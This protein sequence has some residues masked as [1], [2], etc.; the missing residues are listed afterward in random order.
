MFTRHVTAV[1]LTLVVAVPV[2][3]GCSPNKSSSEAIPAGLTTVEFT[4]TEELS[5][6]RLRQ[7][8]DRIARRA[9]SLGIKG[10][11]ARAGSG[12]VTVTAPGDHRERI[13]GLGDIATLSF[14]PVLLAAPAAPGAPAPELQAPDREAGVTTDLKRAFDAL[15]CTASASPDPELPPP[16]VPASESTVMCDD[17][18][19]NKYAL[20]PA[21]ITERDVRSA[22]SELASTSVQW[23]VQLTLTKE[24]GSVFADTSEKLSALSPPRNQIAIAIDDSVLTAPSVIGRIPGGKVQISGD[25]D[26]AEVERIAAM[27]GS[28][29]LP[30]AFRP[31]KSAYVPD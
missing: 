7:A 1:A 28:G 17:S 30:I 15:D 9:G 3:G 13:T 4:P 21:E 25:F 10:A 27:I 29:S 11:K 24:G 14:R 18:A 5:D 19:E 16:A 22:K 6:E 8:A 23:Q 2:L 20:G 31:T 12:T 26:R